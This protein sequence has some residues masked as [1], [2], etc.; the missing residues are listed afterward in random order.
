MAEEPTI[1]CNPFR[2]V[3]HSR[4]LPRVAR[5]CAQPW[6][7]GGKR[8]RRFVAQRPVDYSSM[9]LPSQ[10]LAL[11]LALNATPQLIEV[12]AVS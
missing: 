3:K 4:W 11:G 10:S 5:C 9:S 12:S 8:L 2:V 7:E 1:P 6:A